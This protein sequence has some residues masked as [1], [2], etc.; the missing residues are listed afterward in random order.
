[1]SKVRIRTFAA[2]A[3]LTAFLLSGSAGFGIR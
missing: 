1:M 3:S 2:L